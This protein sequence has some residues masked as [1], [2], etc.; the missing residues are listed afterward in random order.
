MPSPTRAARLPLPSAAAEGGQED[1]RVSGL[2]ALL[3][4][5]VR[6]EHGVVVD[7]ADVLEE[8]PGIGIE[9]DRADRRVLA[10]QGGQEVAEALRA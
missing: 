1:E 3:Q 2:D 4:H 9:N 5:R 6:A 7:N 10:R 8:L